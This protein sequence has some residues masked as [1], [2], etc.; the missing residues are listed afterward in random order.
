MK[1][2]DFVLKKYPEAICKVASAVRRRD[3][4]TI[5]DSDTGLILGKAPVRESTAWQNAKRDI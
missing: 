5:I 1:A 4:F 2:K 3:W